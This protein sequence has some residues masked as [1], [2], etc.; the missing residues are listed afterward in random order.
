MVYGAI[1]YNYKLKLVICTSVV[2]ALEYRNNIG[3]SE[4]AET[5]DRVYGQGNSIFVQDDAPAHNFTYHSGQQILQISTFLGKHGEKCT[6]FK[7]NGANLLIWQEIGAL[8]Q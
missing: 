1:G 2:D 3:K 8:N 6:R 7:L 5:L 4:M